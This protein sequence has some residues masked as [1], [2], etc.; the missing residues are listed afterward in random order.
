MCVC[1]KVKFR[2]PCP[3]RQKCSKGPVRGMGRVWFRVEGLRI[4]MLG[5]NNERTLRG[6]GEGIGVTV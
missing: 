1:A 5:L 4:K 3:L 6:S 2:K